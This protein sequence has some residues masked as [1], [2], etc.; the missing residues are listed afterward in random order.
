MD[1]VV[2][3]HLT[4]DG[5]LLNSPGQAVYKENCLETLNPSLA[6][7]WHPTANG[8][9]TARD[10]RPRSNKKVWWLCGKG[11]E[12]QASIDGRSRGNG[13][14]YCSGRLATSENCL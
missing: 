4:Y 13:C 8:S 7:E 11:H 5:L 1:E 9:L 3:E 10:V 14:P 12:W 6:K 2:K